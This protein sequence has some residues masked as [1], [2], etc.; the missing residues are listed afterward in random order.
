MNIDQFYGQNAH[1]DNKDDTDAE[2]SGETTEEE[3]DPIESPIKARI[4]V[5]LCSP[6]YDNLDEAD[7]DFM[8]CSLVEF[9][10]DTKKILMRN[11]EQTENAAYPTVTDMTQ[12]L[13]DPIWTAFFG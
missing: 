9:Q 2:K 6:R 8:I 12:S 11:W 1:D 5:G 7:L 4:Q 3:D 13:T 10:K